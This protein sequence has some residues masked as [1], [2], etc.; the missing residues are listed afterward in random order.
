MD[1]IEQLQD[2]VKILTKQ[3]NSLTELEI[4]KMSL[5]IRQNELLQELIHTIKYNK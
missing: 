3:Y 2:L 5:S 1:E 4:I